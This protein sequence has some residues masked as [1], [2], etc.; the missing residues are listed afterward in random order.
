MQASMALFA[1]DIA[2]VRPQ[3][4]DPAVQLGM[5]FVMSGFNGVIGWRRTHPDTHHPHADTRRL[6]NLINNL[7]A[8]TPR[9]AP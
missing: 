6:I 4:T 7:A 5:T 1:P 9:G 8:L 3:T 2:H